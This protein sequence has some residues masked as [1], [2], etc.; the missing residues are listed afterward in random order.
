MADKA[1]QEMADILFPIAQR[2]VVTHIENPRAASTAQLLQAGLRT[3]TS[4]VAEQSVA[5]ALARAAELTPPNTVIVVTGSI[6]LVGDTM[7]GLGIPA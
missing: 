4:T 7:K 5:A 2:V 6:F 1:I 3:G